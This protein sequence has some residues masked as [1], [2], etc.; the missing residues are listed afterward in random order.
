MKIPSL[1]L[2][3]LYTYGSLENTPEGVVFG[4]KNRLSDATITGLNRVSFDGEDVPLDQVTLVL[5][6]GQ[7]LSPADLAADPLDFALRQELD[8]VARRDP[9]SLGKHRIEVHFDSKPFGRLKLKV[10][11]SIS[12]E[13]EERTTIPRSRWLSRMARNSEPAIASGI[14]NIR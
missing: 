6:D 4:L 12:E 13:K 9:L 10:D 5:T 14:P 1:V 7:E 3:Q 2:K 11:G 8:V